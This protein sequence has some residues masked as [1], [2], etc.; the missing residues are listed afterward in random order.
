MGDAGHA[1]LKIPSIPTGKKGFVKS[2]LKNSK[3]D[4]FSNSSILFGIGCGSV[5]GFLILLI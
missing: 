2:W 5:F 1:K 4:S 3:L